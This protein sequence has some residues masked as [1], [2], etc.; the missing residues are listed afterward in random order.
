MSAGTDILLALQ[1][2]EQLPRDVREEF[3]NIVGNLQTQFG[4][5]DGWGKWNDVTWAADLF[6][7][8]VG[9]WTPTRNHVKI[10]AWSMVNETMTV[11][12]NIAQAP[13]TGAPHAL[14]IRIPNTNYRPLTYDISGV[15]IGGFAFATWA[16]PCVI[17]ED[18]LV[19]RA[20]LCGVISNTNS[21]AKNEIAIVFGKAPDAA[22]PSVNFAGCQAQIS[23]KVE[24]ISGVLL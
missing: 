9:T 13:T 6:S 3:R 10:L 19:Y 15:Q 14:R 2:E 11:V 4:K 8:D 22:I 16:A 5:D 21:V 24:P 18:T 7:T 12:V 1:H 20:G 23:F 17:W